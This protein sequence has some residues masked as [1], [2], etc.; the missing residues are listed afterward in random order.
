MKQLLDK[1]KISISDNGYRIFQTVFT[2]LYNAF[3]T[4]KEIVI[5]RNS[6]DY[7]E[8]K[9]CAGESAGLTDYS[10]YH[11]KRILSNLNMQGFAKVYKRKPERPADLKEGERVYSFLEVHP[12]DK[13][14]EAF[15]KGAVC[16]I[17]QSTFGYGSEIKVLVD[18]VG[19]GKGYP[20][21]DYL[22]KNFFLP[23]K[24]Q[25]GVA[26]SRWYDWERALEDLFEAKLAKMKTEE[27][28]DEIAKLI[29]ELK[30]T[31]PANR[32]TAAVIQRNIEKC[33]KLTF[34]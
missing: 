9:K 34:A 24:E 10:Y 3:S 28:K 22:Q 14:S 23:A 17:P 13:G 6:M 18:S 25:Y 12:T 27:A 30:K 19:I 31:L 2:N 26:F 15:E 11:V 4:G 5:V 16:P 7:I 8:A 32:R 29:E 21:F 1:D 20:G 33:A